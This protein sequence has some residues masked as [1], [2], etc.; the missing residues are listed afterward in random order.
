MYWRVKNITPEHL[1]KQYGLFAILGF[2]LFFNFILFI[3]RPNPQKMVNKEMKLNFEQFARTVTQQLLDNSY[4]TYQQSM[5][6][7]FNGE[8]APAV[9]AKLRQTDRLPKSDEE[10][11]ATVR[12]L[13]NQRQVSAV[14]IDSIFQSEPNANSLIPVDVSGVVAINSA[15]ENIPK[16]PVP[17]HFHFLLG[18]NQSTQTP[19][20]ADFSE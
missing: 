15:D 10:I 8:L 14:R 18:L 7:L 20:V 6:N 19:A 4:I 12:T 3:T 13:T 11:Q 5:K 17:F 1:F 16:D 2:S 9:M